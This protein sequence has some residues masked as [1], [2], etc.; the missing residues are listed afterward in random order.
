MERSEGGNVGIQ[1]G[2][3]AALEAGAMAW[4]GHVQIA[5]VCLAHED[6]DVTKAIFGCL[7]PCIL[8]CLVSN[9]K[10]DSFL[11][12]QLEDTKGRRIRIR[13]RVNAYLRI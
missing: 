3:V 1:K 10:E 2:A 12:S 7:E 13:I 11:F 9:V 4:F 8:Y 6:T 5:I